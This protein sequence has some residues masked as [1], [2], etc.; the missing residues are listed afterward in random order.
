[1]RQ[2]S[3][4]GQSATR[5]QNY[6]VDWPEPIKTFKHYLTIVNFEM[7]TSVA[8]VAPH[9]HALQRGATLCGRWLQDFVTPGCLGLTW[10]YP[11]SFGVMLL[12]PLIVFAVCRRVRVCRVRVRVHVCP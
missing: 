9:R 11:M 2:Y 8:T 10:T 1:M 5:A 4:V 12:L 3:L 6:S 7:V